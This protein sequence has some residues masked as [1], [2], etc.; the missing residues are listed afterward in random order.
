MKMRKV[1]MVALLISLAASFASPSFAINL[2]S[3]TLDMTTAGGTTLNTGSWSTNTGDGLAQLGVRQSGIFLNTPINLTFDLGEI[4]IALAPGL[5]TFELFGTHPAGSNNYYG[6]AL[7]FNSHA[8]PPDMAVYNA[9]NSLGPFTVTPAGTQVMGSANGGLFLDIAPG[10]ALYTA[11]NG[12]TVELVAFNV[13]FDALTSP[14]IVSWGSST[15]LDS[16]PD[17]KANLTLNYTPAAPIPGTIFLLGAG[18]GLLAI[19]SRR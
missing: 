19:Y 15:T 1:F 18:M 11:P 7:F 3:L 8:T 14:N 10:S 5:N 13:F 6:L 12:S 17:I 9:N 4:S 16:Y 2:T